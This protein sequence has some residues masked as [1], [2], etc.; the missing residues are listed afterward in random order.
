MRA[1][2]SIEPTLIQASAGDYTKFIAD[3]FAHPARV[4]CKTVGATEADV[5]SAQQVTLDEEGLPT[6]TIV[7]ASGWSRTVTLEVPGRVVID[8]LF[9]HL[10]L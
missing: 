8:D 4:V 6:A 9:W 3:E 2:D 1:F 10:R 5:M 7:A